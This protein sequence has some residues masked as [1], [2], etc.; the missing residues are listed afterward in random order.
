[1]FDERFRPKTRRA[2]QQ[3][4]GFL[5]KRPTRHLLTRGLNQKQGKQANMDEEMDVVIW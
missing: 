3:G 4:T 1:L 2:G 5:L